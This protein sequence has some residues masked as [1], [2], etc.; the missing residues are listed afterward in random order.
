MN[1]RFDCRNDRDNYNKGDQYNRDRNFNRGDSE[2]NRAPA[3]RED[4][5]SRPLKNDKDEDI[6]NK[7]PKLKPDV[8]PV[9]L[10]IVCY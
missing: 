2:R 9:S 7:L 6:E 8:K 4:E 3:G 10:S 5:D 1:N